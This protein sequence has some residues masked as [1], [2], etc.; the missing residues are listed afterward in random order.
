MK[1]LIESLE[2]RKSNTLE[3]LNKNY[4]NVF[5]EQNHLKENSIEQLY[6]HYGYYIAI[7]DILNKIIDHHEDICN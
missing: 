1:E 5:D 4:P 6:W 3:W 7:K 2:N